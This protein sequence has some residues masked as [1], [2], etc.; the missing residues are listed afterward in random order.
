MYELW[1][2]VSQCG[3]VVRMVILDLHSVMEDFC[4]S[5]P[6]TAQL[7]RVRIKCR[8]GEQCKQFWIPT[9]KKGGLTM[10]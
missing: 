2:P 4:A 5:H 8:R 1:G 3:V 10:K 9:R 7:Y 6:F